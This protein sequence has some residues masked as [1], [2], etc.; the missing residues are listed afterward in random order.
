MVNK[1]RSEMVYHKLGNDDDGE[2]SEPN[3]EE[4]KKWNMKFPQR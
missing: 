1:I 2:Y 4:S 3:K